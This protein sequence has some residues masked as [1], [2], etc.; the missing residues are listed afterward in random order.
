MRVRLEMH[1]PQSIAPAVEGSVALN[2]RRRES[3]RLE[4]V[5]AESAGKEASL[6][7]TALLVYQVDAFER[8]SRELHSII[9]SSGIGTTKRHPH[10]RT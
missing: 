2:E 4:F 6:V 10:D 9:R 7:L 8:C 5:P 1:A 3:V